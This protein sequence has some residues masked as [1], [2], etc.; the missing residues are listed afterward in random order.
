MNRHLIIGRQVADPARYPYF[1][2][3]DIDGEFS[4]GG[5]LIQS[6]F[7]LTASHC[8]PDAANLGRLT[9]VIGGHN[10]E[11]GVSHEVLDAYPHLA[12]DDWF[13]LSNDVALLK[14][15]PVTENTTLVSFQSS[16]DFLQPGDSVT[17]MGLGITEEG[18]AAEALKDVELK[19]V[20]KII[21]DR[22]YDGGIN[23]KSMFCATN[24]DDSGATVDSCQGD[25]GGP[26]VVLGNTPEEDIQVG[27]VSWGGECG[28]PNKPGVY[29]DVAYLL[30]WIESIICKHSDSPPE[31]CEIKIDTE[32]GPIFL[33][34][35]EVICRDFGGAFYADWWHQFQRCDW[36][37]EKGR[38]NWYCKEYN[39]AW[40]QC[41]LTCSKCTY[42][43]DD[44]FY[45]E[46]Y[47]ANYNQSSS[48]GAMVSVFVLTFILLCILL[49]YMGCC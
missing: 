42:E 32:I 12:Y 20:D 17:V 27:V 47:E 33:D 30:P 15:S 29:A 40:V 31:G 2:R 14:I 34:P 1:V 48:S 13:S 41:P 21:C 22:Q 3:L 28:D 6:D 8:L 26:I 39:E 45:F 10:L 11:S 16:R 37:R 18:I 35:D 38:I 9:V 23:R 24:T 43:A 46:S 5:S 36:L 19:I 4:C 49:S 44:D 25:S 7:V